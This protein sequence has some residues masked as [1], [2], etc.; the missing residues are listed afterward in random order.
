MPRLLWQGRSTCTAIFPYCTIPAQDNN[1]T[2]QTKRNAH[3]IAAKAS[4]IP[5]IRTTTVLCYYTATRRRPPTSTLY[6]TIFLVFG[7]GARRHSSIC[8]IRLDYLRRRLLRLALVQ[9]KRRGPS[10]FLATRS[11]DHRRISCG[12][13]TLSD[14]RPG[15]MISFADA[16]RWCIGLSCSQE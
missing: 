8:A 4:F 3:A 15:L 12:Y 1:V 16:A 7:V 14:V 13:S 6:R 5:V 11:S 2:C 10:G 9:R